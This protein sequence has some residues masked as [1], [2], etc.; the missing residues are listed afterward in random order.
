MSKTHDMAVIHSSAESDWR[1][2]LA[3][4]QALH[5]EFSFAIDLAADDRS[6]LCYL[7]FGPGSGLGEDALAADWVAELAGGWGFLNPPYS[8]QKAKAWPGRIDP[9]SG[10]PALNPYRIEHWL[11]KCWTESQRGAKI[12]GLFPFAPQTEWYRRYVYGHVLTSDN[13]ASTGWSGHAAIQERRLPHRISFLTPDGP[14][15][16]NAGVNTAV[17]VWQPTRRF[18]GPWTP[19]TLYWSYR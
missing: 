6:R 17:I 1:T 16:N 11:E 19:Q 12:V 7:Y 9:V 10:L 14:E 2:P 3:C 8:R 13:P 5:E 18:V 4:Y 15:S